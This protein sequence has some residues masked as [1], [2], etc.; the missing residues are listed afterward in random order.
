MDPSNPDCENYDPCYGKKTNADFGFYVAGVDPVYLYWRNNI[1]EIDTLYTTQVLLCTKFTYDS[2]KWKVGLEANYRTGDSVTV[3]FGDQRVGDINVTCI[4]YRKAT[5]TCF[6]GDDGIDTVTKKLYVAKFDQIPILGKFKGMFR[7]DPVNPDSF[8]V[9]F[10]SR[11]GEMNCVMD[12]MDHKKGWADHTVTTLYT[13]DKFYYR[14]S[15]MTGF[16]KTTG[17]Y[18]Y[19][20]YNRTTEKIFLKF[21]G[22]RDLNDDEKDRIWEGKRIN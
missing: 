20:T 16:P 22:Y 1:D 9:T 12:S 7:N 15:G 4:V 8:I 19:G 17:Y 18:P 6:P 13:R 5:T 11:V 10:R 3:G 2:V 21:R 14:G